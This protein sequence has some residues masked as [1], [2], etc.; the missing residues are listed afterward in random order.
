[1]AESGSPLQGVLVTLVHDRR[2]LAIF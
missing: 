2:A 1:V